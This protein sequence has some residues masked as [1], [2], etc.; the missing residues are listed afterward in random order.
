MDNEAKWYILGQGNKQYGK[1][2]AQQMI[3]WYNQGKLNDESFVACSGMKSWVKFKDTELMQHI[4]KEKAQI[5]LCS[6][7]GIMD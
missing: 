4:N 6:F 2:T 1:Y 3:D 7:L 5:S